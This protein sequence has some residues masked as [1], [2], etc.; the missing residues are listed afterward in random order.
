MYHFIFSRS[1]TFMPM[2]L[3]A[4]VAMTCLQG[5]AFAGTSPAQSDHR[6]AEVNSTGLN[7][8]KSVDVDALDAR[9]KRAARAVCVPTDWRNLKQAAASTRCQRDAI[10][11]AQAERDV[12]VARAEAMQMAAR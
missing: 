1:R 12:M 10:A 4:A 11:N 8:A 7:L 6:I 3:M 5:A 2:A 9:I